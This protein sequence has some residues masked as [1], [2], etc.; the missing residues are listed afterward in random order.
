MT[1]NRGAD[2]TTLPGKHGP[3]ET[4]AGGH[5]RFEETP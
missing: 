5:H 4:N 1:P 3:S 2:T